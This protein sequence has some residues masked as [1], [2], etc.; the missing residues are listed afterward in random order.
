MSDEFPTPQDILN[1]NP[2]VVGAAAGYAV[3]RN[4]QAT[5]RNLEHLKKEVSS[6]QR[7]LVRTRQQE[8]TEH[9]R[10]EQVFQ[11]SS[12]LDELISQE[13]SPDVLLRLQHLDQAFKE[14]GL[15]SASFRSLSDKEFLN[16]TKL[17]FRR[18]LEEHRAS[19]SAEALKS[20]DALKQWSTLSE[21]AQQLLVEDVE[22]AE[23][24]QKLSEAQEKHSEAEAALSKTKGIVPF[25]RDGEHLWASRAFAAAV[26][27]AF[28]GITIPIFWGIG[29]LP[30]SLVFFGVAAAAFGYTYQERFKLNF[31]NSM[32]FA[33]AKKLLQQAERRLEQCENERFRLQGSIFECNLLPSELCD[34]LADSD[35]PIEERR[36]KCAEASAYGESLRKELR[37]SE[38]VLDQATNARLK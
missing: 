14:L 6:M 26:V 7:E 13:K 11:V 30:L 8:E 19:M 9:R 37:V 28:A 17:R 3:N 10:R 22:F 20:L 5:N 33:E 2:G 18:A 29:Q 27:V 38:A 23:A 24:T 32:E 1:D 34:F 16:S 12:Q 4:I 36:T 35:H 21:C 31:S 15:T 25:A